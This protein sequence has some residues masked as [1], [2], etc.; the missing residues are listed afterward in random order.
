M[1]RD[2]TAPPGKQDL[3]QTKVK[4]LGSGSGEIFRFSFFF[5]RE[6]MQADEEEEGG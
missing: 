2:P 3:G 1:V 6:K 4:T 5:E